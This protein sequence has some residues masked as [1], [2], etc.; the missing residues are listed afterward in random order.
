MPQ[1]SAAPGKALL[2]H[3][4]QPAASPM[5]ALSI[6][7]VLEITGISRATLYMHINAG[8]IVARKLGSR[9]IV[10]VSDLERYLESLPRLHLGRETADA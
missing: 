6:T 1:T 3:H 9:T 7:Q 2:A 4:A 10:M 5:K 8:H